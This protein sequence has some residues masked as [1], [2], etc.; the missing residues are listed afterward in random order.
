MFLDA[1][2]D[3]MLVNIDLDGNGVIDYSEFVTVASNFKEMLTEKNLIESFKQ[4]DVDNDGQIQVGDLRRVLGINWPDEQEIG[5]FIS[6]I[7]LNDDGQI[8]F[9]EFKRMM[10]A[11]IKRNSSI[12]KICKKISDP[13]GINALVQNQ[14]LS[15]SVLYPS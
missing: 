1:E 8:N 11:F 9:K 13:F 10:S 2:I 15:H 14:R 4:F 7:D 3:Q 12:P 6:S 5:D